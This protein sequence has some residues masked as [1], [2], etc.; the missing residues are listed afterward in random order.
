M[1]KV[2]L[3]LGSNLGHR[4]QMLRTAIGLLESPDLRILR[5]SSVY[6]TEPVE[7]RRQPWFLNLVVEAETD[8]VPIELLAR[9]RKIETQL[10]RKR[11]IAKGPRTIDID[12]LL[13]GDSV[14][15][16]GAL[17]IPHPRMTERRFVLEPMAELAADLRHPVHRRTMRDLVG[18]TL[19][20]TVRKLSFLP[21][22][23][24]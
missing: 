4:G 19:A 11:L 2:Y 12:I 7:H 18:V 16:S 17:V 24:A 9:V 13:Y 21:D 5:I 20:Q 10:G 22:A 8:L 1:K 3:S 23:P 15:E 6:E 14:I